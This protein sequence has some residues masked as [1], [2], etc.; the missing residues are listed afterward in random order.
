MA[1]GFDF[2]GFHIQWRR[3]IGTNQWHV[4]T[5]IADRPVRSLKAKIRALTNR[6]SQQDPKAVL[7]RLGQIMRGWS[8]Y[9]RHAVCKHTFARL[10]HF[11][12]QRVARWSARCTTG[13]GRTSADSSPA[14]TA[15]G[16]H[17]RRTGSRCSTSPRCRLP[18]IDT[19][20][21]PDTLDPETTGM[22]AESVESPLRGDT[23]GGFGERPGETDREQSRHRAPGR[24]IRRQ[25]T[26]T[27]IR[28]RLVQ[29]LQ[30]RDPQGP[31]RVATSAYPLTNTAYISVSPT[32]AV[33][34]RGRS[35]VR[36]EPCRR[37][38]VGP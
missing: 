12:W 32:M 29:Q 34:G 36:I 13:R 28:H 21:H 24:L 15:G 4:Y 22:T 30:R 10:A 38:R 14:A 19:E 23:H 25:D 8:N 18:G 31:L 7:I 1:D 26:L 9:F 16:Y 5:F 33:T 35:A 27:A 6:T 20:A 2:L 11:V 37:H 3:K 17:C